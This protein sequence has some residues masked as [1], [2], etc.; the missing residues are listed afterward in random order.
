[1]KKLVDYEAL[2]IVEYWIVDYLALGASRYTGKPKQPTVSVYCL[3]EG[4]YKVTQF[5][6][7]RPIESLVFSELNLT[8][9]QIVKFGIPFN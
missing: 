2:G 5:Q 6:D 9:N 1:M 3:V 4:E 8:G 7:D